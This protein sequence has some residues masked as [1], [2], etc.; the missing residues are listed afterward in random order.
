MVALFPAPLTPLGGLDAALHARG[1]VVLDA[2]SVAA[3]SGVA[4]TE[5]DALL[6]SWED[7]RADEYLKD[8]GRYRKRRH[9]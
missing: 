1:F 4:R 2:A 3:L 7:L 5:F 9:A 8:G 6:P